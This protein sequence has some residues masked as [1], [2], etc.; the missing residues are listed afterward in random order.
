MFQTQRSTSGNSHFA[1]LFFVVRSIKRVPVRSK[2]FSEVV[3]HWEKPTVPAS[4]SDS[5]RTPIGPVI[6]TLTLEVIKAMCEKLDLKSWCFTCPKRLVD[7]SRHFFHPTIK[8]D[9]FLKVPYSDPIFRSL[10]GSIL[11][12]S[13]A[14][15][16]SE[17]SNYL[18]WSGQ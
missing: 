10:V 12:P 5:Q 1:T 3:S 8:S 16:H 7:I 13:G 4:F 2:C 15:S 14:E 18:C 9:L 11:D 6:L 17:L